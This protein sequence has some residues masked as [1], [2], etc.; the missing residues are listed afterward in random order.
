LKSWFVETS[1]DGEDWRRVVRDEDNKQL[2]G[3]RFTGTFAVAG[4]GKCR[5]IRFVNIGRNHSRND[6]LR[7]SS[8][9]CERMEQSAVIA[10]NGDWNYQRNGSTPILD[11][12]DVES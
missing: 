12:L 3:P 10:I 6:Q 9:N 11:I 4:R 2:N 7:I 1:V 8:K 5:F